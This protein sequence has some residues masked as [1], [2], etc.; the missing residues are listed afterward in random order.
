MISCGT[1]LFVIDN[2]GAKKVKCLKILGGSY[3]QY[4]FVGNLI[5]V[6]LQRINPLKKLK[7]GEIFK[8]VIIAIKKK[9][10]RVNGS[11]VSFNINGV[12]IVNNKKLPLATRILGPVMAEL[13]QYNFAK[14]LSMSTI[15]I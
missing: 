3:K 9:K 11:L 1:S 12:V 7:K 2:S 10:I 15:A 13:R 8:A 14:I 4:G 6:S 5:V